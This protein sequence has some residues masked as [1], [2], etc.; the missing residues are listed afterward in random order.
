MSIHGLLPAILSGDGMRQRRAVAKAITLLESTRTDHRAAADDLLT[1]MLPHTGRSFRLGISGVPGVGKSTF[2]ETL[3]LFLIAR[4]HRVAV[5]TIDPSSTVSGGSI[6]GDKTRMEKLSVDE[7][8][9]IRP[10][11]SSGTLGG[12]AEKTREA[13]LVCEAAGYDVVVVETVGVGQSETAVAGMTDMF[14]LMQLPNAG[15]DLQAI[16]KGVMELADLVVI[17]KADIDRDAATR[18]QAQITSALR[19]FGHQGNP[20]HAQRMQALHAVPGSPESEIRFWQPQVMQLS[21][22][23][24]T[25]VDAFWAAVAEFRRLQG[26][27]GRLSQRREKQ[28]L[29]WMWERIDAGLKLAFRRHAAV[30]GLL[31]AALSQVAAGTLP[32][33]TASRQLLAAYAGLEPSSSIPTASTTHTPDATP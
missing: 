18:A 12:V 25:G 3:G 10:S 5:L 27:N 28:A 8:A 11:P 6:L 33:S 13:M 30:R 17:N 15:D 4:G 9:Y 22:L 16:K 24:G 21:A 29:A 26:A 20:A 32:A 19:L 2:I 31:P 1:A 7:R 14:V 23:L